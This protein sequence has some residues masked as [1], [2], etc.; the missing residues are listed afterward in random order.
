MQ[1]FWPTPSLCCLFAE[2]VSFKCQ[3]QVLKAVPL[4]R[5]LGA[6]KLDEEMGAM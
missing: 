6:A 2:S 4:G 3:C 5:C 1:L